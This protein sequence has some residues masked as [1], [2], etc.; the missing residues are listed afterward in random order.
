MIDLNIEILIPIPSGGKKGLGTSRMMKMIGM[1]FNRFKIRKI[2]RKRKTLLDMQK[3]D[4]LT[5]KEQ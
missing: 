2:A 3:L 5:I 4:L 1:T